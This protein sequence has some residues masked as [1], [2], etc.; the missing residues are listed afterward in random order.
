MIYITI[1]CALT[2]LAY[3]NTNNTWIDEHNISPLVSAFIYGPPPISSSRFTVI[4]YLDSL[5]PF[6]CNNHNHYCR[7]CI[8]RNCTIAV[9]NQCNNPEWTLTNVCSSMWKISEH[10]GLR[11]YNT[12]TKL[13]DRN[14][15]DIMTIIMAK[16][17][18]SYNIGKLFIEA[19]ISNTK[20]PK[21]FKV[22]RE[23]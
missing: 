13:N 17:T 6:S 11:F 9:F 23:Q 8:L 2:H 7:R 3:S 19:A 16:S 20:Q 10:L 1:V 22:P 12:T 21:E 5:V 15:P 18:K 4:A 14:S